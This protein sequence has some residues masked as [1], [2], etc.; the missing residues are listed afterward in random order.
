MD[1]Q[2]FITS[3]TYTR[4]TFKVDESGKTVI[5]G[6]TDGSIRVVC[7]N[8]NESDWNG[9]SIQTIQH[10]KPH[11]G[12]VNQILTNERI[13]VSASEDQTIFIY[14]IS[15]SLNEIFLTPIGFVRINTTIRRI[16]CSDCDV[17]KVNNKF[18]FIYHFRRHYMQLIV[19]ILVVHANHCK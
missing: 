3:N 10:S 1:K 8:I 11:L 6:F 14:N 18:G 13:M 12:Q 5:F 4:I 16:L 9:S 17:D 15:S 7:F 19:K 2:L